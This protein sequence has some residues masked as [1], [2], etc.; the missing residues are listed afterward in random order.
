[1]THHWKM[2]QL[3][4]MAELMVQGVSVHD[5]AREINLPEKKVQDTARWMI[6]R[7]TRKEQRRPAKPVSY[8]PTQWTPEMERRALTL[9]AEGYGHEYIGRKMKLTADRVR[10]MIDRK[11]AQYGA[12]SKTHLI[13]LLHLDNY[14][15]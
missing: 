5:I 11:K 2:P 3:K 14:F 13:H 12:R 7:V 1:M 4:K 15:Q 8:K 10:S 6:K 9:F